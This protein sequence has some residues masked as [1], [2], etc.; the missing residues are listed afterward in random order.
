MRTASL[1]AVCT[2]LV[3]FGCGGAPIKPADD[4]QPHMGESWFSHRAEQLGVS[5]AQAKAR[6]AAISETSPPTLDP[7][8]QLEGATIWARVCANCHG[9]FGDP[10]TATTRFEPSPR[11]WSGFGPSMGFLFG[12]DKMRAGI[13]TKIAEGGADRT[14]DQPSPMPAWKSQLSKEQIWALVHYIE[15]L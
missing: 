8:T 5:V 6:D 12:G 7:D 15:T 13:Y 14:D 11:D 3:M 1:S 9:Q 10:S 2:A 4:A